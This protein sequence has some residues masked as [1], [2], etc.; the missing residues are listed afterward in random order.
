LVPSSQSSGGGSSQHNWFSIPH[1]WQVP[2]E[3][4]AL[5]PKQV[6]LGGQHGW[7]G[8][9]GIERPPQGTHMPLLQIKVG[10]MHGEPV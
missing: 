5:V 10:P 2:P 1:G 6:S 9:G 7:G 3:Q 4:T 8:W